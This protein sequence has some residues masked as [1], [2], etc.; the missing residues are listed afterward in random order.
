MDGENY[1]KHYC[2][3]D[4]LGVPL[5][6]E[7]PISFV[8]SIGPALAINPATGR[9][10][11]SSAP[12][13]QQG[14][15]PENLWRNA[16][17]NNNNNNNNNKKCKQET[18]SALTGGKTLINCWKGWKGCPDLECQ[19]VRQWLKLGSKKQKN[20]M[21]KYVEN[22]NLWFHAGPVKMLEIID[23]TTLQI[24][25]TNQVRGKRPQFH[26]WA[27]SGCPV[28]SGEGSQQVINC[29]AGA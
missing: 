18:S 28:A 25:A 7:T 24:A 15:Q 13:W 4:D 20:G 14:C 27:D 17:A 29:V 10:S 3:M 26:G 11:A 12:S 6:W 22:P 21:Q 2:L 23:L 5:F 16:T 8:A 1:S 19:S 9:S